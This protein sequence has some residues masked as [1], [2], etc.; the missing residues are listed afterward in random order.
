MPGV[1]GSRGHQCGW[2]GALSWGLGLTSRRWSLSHVAACS[3]QDGLAARVEPLFL[4]SLPTPSLED[5]HCDPDWGGVQP[6][7]ESLQGVSL[8][9]ASLCGPSRKALLDPRPFPTG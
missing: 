8:T 4:L 1:Q 7:K 5:P 6:R 2:S 9:G 3:A